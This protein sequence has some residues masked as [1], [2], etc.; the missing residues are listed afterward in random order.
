MPEKKKQKI[1]HHDH[2]FKAVLSDPAAARDLLEI[3]LPAQWRER[4]D[5]NTLALQPG[6]F[7]EPDLKA[8]YSD[9]LYRVKIG[10][11]ESGYIYVTI[12]HQSRAD[13]LIGFRLMRYAIAAMQQHITQH[14]SK[15]VPVVIPLLFY[16]GQPS[17]HPYPMNWLACFD[18]PE[19]AREVY[20]RDFPLADITAIPDEDLMQHKSVA[21]LSLVMKH[22]RTRDMMEF[23]DDIA[24]LTLKTALTAE[25]FSAIMHYILWSG[26][27]NTDVRAFLEE[28]RHKAPQREGEL[29][30]MA[31][32]LIQEGVLKGIQKGSQET[33]E[34]IARSMLNKGM[35]VELINEITRLPIETIEA[36]KH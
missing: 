8:Y 34:N 17:P 9:I 3:H 22:I 19:L 2:V 13:A 35:N 33:A 7:I 16:A 5:M 20:S 14:K 24:L 18:Q 6:S 23:I 26:R 10:G 21:L 4:C 11:G 32:Q 31:E 36:L 12:E 27:D 28:L 1:S 29:M 30:T 15:T 25:Q